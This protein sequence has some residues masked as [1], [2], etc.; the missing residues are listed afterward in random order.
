[1]ADLYLGAEGPLENPDLIALT[2][3]LSGIA[4]AIAGYTIAQATFMREAGNYAVASPID[5]FVVPAAVVALFF[6][7]GA[8]LGASAFW[9][10]SRR[11][12]DIVPLRV[13][14]G[15]STAGV[16]A[17]VGVLLVGTVVD[18]GRYVAM[19]ITLLAAYYGARLTTSL[20][21]PKPPA[22]GVRLARVTLTAS[23]L[24]IATLLVSYR[25]TGWPGAAAPIATR[26]AWARK[27]FKEHYPQAVAF[28]KGCPEVAGHL[29]TLSAIGPA[30]GSNAVYYGQ[31]EAT[32]E[33]TLEVVGSQ[34]ATLVH[35]ATL[36]RYHPTATSPAWER[37]GEMLDGAHAVPLG[38][39]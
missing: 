28:V 1:V 31:G 16:L 19:A 8:Y 10:A 33:F 11:D 20:R 30:A 7:L 29:G 37:S 35:V 36:R 27:T 13:S 32:G 22:S 6:T 2:T 34:G 38:C 12:P 5:D 21:R 24:L 25:P 26:D 23:T 18:P 17:F 9:L 3:V 15:A 14:L 39:R 4:A